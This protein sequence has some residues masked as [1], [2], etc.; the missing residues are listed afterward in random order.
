MLLTE[1]SFGQKTANETGMVRNWWKADWAA[2]R[3]ELDATEWD[4]LEG[5]VADEAWNALKN[6]INDAVSK[7]VPMKPRGSGR[8][9]P[10]MT[11]DILRTVRKKRRLWATAKHGENVEAYRE[12]ERMVK[13]QIR[14]AKR[15]L[16]K[17]L[18]TEN[19]GNSKPFYAY[20]KSK[21]KSKTPVGPLK[22]KQGKI[23]S[24]NKEMAEM[25]NDYFGSVF[26]DEPDGPVP[27]AETSQVEDEL[28]NVRI[29]ADMV[30]KNIRKLKPASAPGP[31]GIGSMVLKELVAQVKVP[32]AAI[33]KKSMESGVVPEDWRTANV[34]PIYK[35]GSKADPGNYRPVSLT[36]VCGKV[37]ESIVRDQLME[38]LSK[39]SLIEESQHGFVPGRSCA[40]NLIEFLD[41]ITQ[42]LDSG[43][44]TDTVFLDF[45]KAFDKVPHRRLI[46]KMRAAGIGGKLLTWVQNWL[47]N[48]R[49]KVV[50]GGESSGWRPVRSGVPQGSVLG[51]VLFLIFIRDIDREAG[52]AEILKKFAD[53]TKV[54][55]KV[56][57]ERDATELQNTLNRLM[58]WAQRWGM[59]FNIK[60]CKVMHSGARNEKK[61]YS[62][63]GQVLESIEEERDIGV[64]VSSDMKPAAQCAKAA[65]T[66]ATVLGQ[67]SCVH[68]HIVTKKFSQP[69]IKGMCAHTWNSHP[70]HG[71]HGCKKTRKFLKECKS[72]RLIW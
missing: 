68:S 63:G 29:T 4:E 43:T 49:Q 34:T 42:S 36:S 31:D 46:E 6:K 18:A 54:G 44:P 19:G 69:S 23:V 30:E 60:K 72:G 5:M 1:L 3:A 21:L 70:T 26:S 22:N 65:K 53:D 52:P 59:E 58:E 8:R 71:I 11:R 16:E 28:R 64:T 7:H 2:M 9:P 48:R 17:K 15:R 62:M 10:W 20:L 13:K 67:L 14:N 37:L 39:N 32:L 33:Y 51:P 12:A 56:Q 41:F 35:K 57:T 47:E 27:R 61:S 55:S 50:L 38:H 66:A 25:L 24:G 40:T 45:A